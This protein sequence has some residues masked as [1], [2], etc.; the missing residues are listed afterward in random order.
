MAETDTKLDPAAERASDAEPKLAKDETSKLTS[1]VTDG[2]SKSAEK[3]GQSYT[4]MA[5]NAATT[6]TSAVKDSVFSMF[7]GGAKK[8]KKAEEDD[9]DKPSGSSKAKKGEDV[10]VSSKPGMILIGG[11]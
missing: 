4:E 1:G 9:V 11:Y 7:G 8:E 5:S 3:S 10:G 2:S 6:A